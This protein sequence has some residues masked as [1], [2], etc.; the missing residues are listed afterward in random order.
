[1][2]FEPGVYS[3]VDRLSDPPGWLQLSLLPQED[4]PPRHGA[5]HRKRTRVRLDA[6]PAWL[7]AALDFDAGLQKHYSLK[8]RQ[9]AAEQVHRMAPLIERKSRE[10]FPHHHEDIA[11]EIRVHLYRKV[12]NAYGNDALTVNG[13]IRVRWVQTVVANKLCSIYRMWSKRIGWTLGPDPES[14]ST[15]CVSSSMQLAEVELDVLV[16]YLTNEQQVARDFMLG[17]MSLRKARLSIGMSEPDFL[18]L[19]EE[20][21]AILRERLSEL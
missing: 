13:E 8:C 6:P 5:P 1:M 2:L 11:S 21:K 17:E 14:V 3:E 18:T 4:A 9:W 15:P 19:V 10:S 16:G 12:L 20:T 7:Q